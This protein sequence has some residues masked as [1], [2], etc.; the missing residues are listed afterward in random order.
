MNRASTHI[1][2]RSLARLGLALLASS[3]TLALAQDPVFVSRWPGQLVGQAMSVTLAGTRA[4]ISAGEAGILVVD[5][6][7]SSAP[8]RIG[9]MDTPGFAYSTAAN[10]TGLLLYVADGEA[11]FH[12]VSIYD[13]SRPT[14]L[15]TR[16]TPGSARAI[17]LRGGF[18]YVADG[19]AGVQIYSLVDPLNP[20]WVGSYPV[21]GE[22][23]GLASFNGPEGLRLYVAARNGG[24]VILRVANPT[25][26][27]LLG[28]YNPGVDVTGIELDGFVALLSA[29]EAGLLAV[30][31]AGTA[32]AS[33]V[34]LGSLDTPGFAY[35]LSRF[36]NSS[37]VQLAD[38]AA[39]L[40][41]ISVTN[42]S[43]PVLLSTYDTPGT[44][45]GA[46]ATPTFAHVADGDGGF[47]LLRVS[48]PSAPQYIGSLQT[49]RRTLGVAV[50][51]GVATLANDLYGVATLD[52]AQ[53]AAPAQL[54]AASTLGSALGI[55]AGAGLACVAEGT[56]G[57][58]RFTLTNPASPVVTGRYDS[59]GFAQSV[60]I[61]GS[62]ASVAD[63]AA[64]VHFLDLTT[65]GNPQRLGGYD[66]PGWARRSTIAGDRA[67]VADTFG[68]LAILSITNP[69]APVLLGNYSGASIFDVKV[70]GDRAYL[71]APGVGLQI[72]DV[73]DPANP[74]LIGSLGDIGS[75]FLLAVAPP[76]AYLAGGTQ[77]VQV[78]DASDPTQP[79][80]VG[81]Y[82]TPGSIN[83]LNVSGNYLYVADGVWGVT[84]LRLVGD[85]YAPPV[86][87][88]Q[89]TDQFGLVGGTATFPATVI[90]AQ[91]MTLQWYRGTAPLDGQTNMSLTLVDLTADDAGSYSLVASNE[92]GTATSATVTLTVL[93]A[94]SSLGWFMM[95]DRST[96]GNWKGVYGTE[97]QLIFGAVTNLDATVLSGSYVSFSTNSTSPQALEYPG[98]VPVTLRL[99]AAQTSAGSIEVDV[100]LPAGPTNRL[101]AYVVEPGGNR[102]QRVE[103]IDIPTGV[104]LAS[105]QV[106]NLT[107]GAYVVWDVTGPVR[108]RC[109]RTAG[110]NCLLSAIFVGTTE[111]Q[112][113]DWRAVPPARQ[114][115]AAGANVVL[116]AGAS[117]SP[118]LSYQWLK[119]GDPV[120]DT[121]SRRGSLTPILSL[122]G[123][124][125]A[126][127]GVY[128]LQ[129]ENA[130]GTIQG[131][132]S[133][134]A[135]TLSQPEKV[136]FVTEDATTR[137][138]WPGVYGLAGHAVPG[139]ST[140]LPPDKEV[141]FDRGELQVFSTNSTDGAALETAADGSV[142]QRYAAVLADADEI[143]ASII[144]PEGETNRVSL[145]FL[146]PDS[147]HP[148]LVEMLDES[149]L[150]VLNSRTISGL[151]NGVYVSYDVNGPVRLR[152]SPVSGG[153]ALLSAVFFG[154][155]TGG[156]P[157]VRI[158]PPPAIIA[159]AG[160]PVAIGAGAVGAPNL[161]WQWRS[162]N[163]PL[164]DTPVRRGTTSP[165]MNFAA[166]TEAEAGAYNVLVTNDLGRVASATT[167]LT[168]VRPNPEKADFVLVDETTT[169]NWKGVYGTEGAVVFGLST[170]LPAGVALEVG[171]SSFIAFNTNTPAA[172]ALERT[173]SPG[174]TNRFSAAIHSTTNL[175]LR[176]G[177]PAGVSNLLTLYCMEASGGRAQRVD[178]IE[179]GTGMVLDSRYLATISNGVYL[180]WMIAG[181]VDIRVTRIAGANALV[182]GL[183]FGMADS[184]PAV[185]VQ[186]PASIIAN[187][188]A[189][190]VLGA[191]LD[192][193][194]ALSFEWMKDGAPLAAAPGRLG[195]ASPVLR[196]MM[197]QSADSGRYTLRVTG[198][199]GE[200]TTAAAQVAVVTSTPAQ[201]RF[202]MEDRSTLGN[203]KGVYGVQ[204]HLIPGLSTNLPSPEHQVSLLD[205]EP[206]TVA[207]NTT[208]PRAL[209]RADTT[210]VTDRF[211]GWQ[212]AEETL[213]VD[214]QL[215]TDATN[216]VAVYFLDAASTRTLR[217]DL[218]GPDGVV[219][220]ART[221]T[222]L[223]GPAYLAYDVN[224]PV[225]LR[226]VRLAGQGA[227]LSGVFIG[228]A[229][230][231]AP[232]V[233]QQPPANVQVADGGRLLLGAGLSG[234]PALGYRWSRNGVPLTDGPQ[235]SGA[236][237]PVL[238]LAGM[239]PADAGSYRLTTTNAFGSVTT[240]EVIV[241][242]DS[243]P[244]MDDAV[245]AIEL[246]ENEN[247]VRIT[248]TGEP[249]T[250][251][252]IQ[253]SS[254]FESWS[255]LR[256]VNTGA[257]T[258]QFTDT[259]DAPEGM[260]VYRAV[261]E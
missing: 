196:L 57:V 130:L 107:N 261:R 248:L 169:G 220:D 42:L 191:G 188:G 176:V 133:I 199:Q 167:T 118:A 243:E 27:T 87:T 165:V 111:N 177:M 168:V 135:M 179:P 158:Q 140:N 225:Q 244:P 149:G 81:S 124:T 145:Y 76:Y 219:L 17:H 50:T 5:R 163:S 53:P 245:L 126:D 47:H 92:L 153:D 178:V 89:P 209:E 189:T 71:A 61:S 63:E 170:N 29:G 59:P 103:L 182:S 6:P 254:D 72:V 96:L 44:A 202:V 68:G 173:D 88:M 253:V 142:T 37:I 192:G 2:H 154:V 125:P 241:L 221:L 185:R 204:G 75:V 117:G 238:D 86:I 155:A 79:V 54:G 258:V 218:L 95:E 256:T 197:A 255:L 159:V 105:Q 56:I 15:A 34:L 4:V 102:A 205:G 67:Y 237:T 43:A 94:G 138:N 41:L 222:G 240:T 212:E 201:G 203:W 30:D 40:H 24:L 90:G 180:T 231:Q 143:T 21:V 239:S 123:M 69:A 45:F 78:V 164:A 18:A 161:R 116:G 36:V 246:T 108:V 151:T 109:V 144:L 113:P 227:V 99:F 97:G 66:T 100:T 12:V 31:T 162:G 26:P 210:S 194:P 172:V 174:V 190:V 206:T 110:A 207:A 139:L 25:A 156:S 223:G 146:A 11:G 233:R 148:Q 242:V 33:P 32:V 134:V 181:P 230:E 235:R 20:F 104:V 228:T 136:R 215:P 1:M 22:A 200:V 211:A 131:A 251:Y 73:S 224:G 39:G 55:A 82:Q 91:P 98:D 14:L 119:D 60:A 77:G 10:E 217:V 46:A 152:V 115:V 229:I 232:T 9:A 213:L 38:G 193:Q 147:D 187:A 7:L 260:R 120:T 48:I 114:V 226:V 198:P 234:S 137:G 70:V 23:V 150:L 252:I 195:I 62:L 249:D 74:T 93:P 259:L 184:A 106:G 121:P 85:D 65:P 160:S 49:L 216:R 35:G 13:P 157:M 64:G 183:F 128:S 208:D 186:P 101:A 127:A 129:V 83:D 141:A 236:T 166:V 247:E 112:P 80:L 58:E 257:G 132:T 19:P 8:Q 51:D 175:T 214:C 28:T 16:D 84:I 3:A 52:V 250:T 122:L 171:V